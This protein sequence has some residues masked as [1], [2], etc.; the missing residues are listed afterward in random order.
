MQ[1]GLPCGGW[2]RLVGGT[3]ER[4]C[5]FGDSDLSLICGLMR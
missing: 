4:M 3:E 5:V 2:F 1:I